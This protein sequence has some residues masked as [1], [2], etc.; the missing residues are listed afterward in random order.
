MVVEGSS[1]SGESLILHMVAI[2]PHIV[3]RK[4]TLIL[5]FSDVKV[6]VMSS[7]Q[8]LRNWR[9]AVKEKPGGMVVVDGHLI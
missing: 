2:V 7:G 6:V 4:V 1:E 8:V 5:S 9:G 3:C